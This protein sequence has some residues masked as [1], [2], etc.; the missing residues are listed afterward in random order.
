MSE[1]RR[2]SGT[3]DESPNGT[4]RDRVFI[5]DTT[6]RDGEQSPGISL[7]VQEKLEIAHQLA[8]LGVDVIEAG[9]PITSPGDMKAVSAI[10]KAVEGPIICGL[11]RTSAQD[12]DAAW[13]AV[14]YS[15]RPRIHTFIA[16]SDI[17][18]ERK[19]QTTREDVVGQARAAV[20][21]AKEFC[22][23]VE[24]SPEDGSRS[25]VEFMAEV[26]KVALEEGAT[27]IN[28]P[29][30]VGYT[31]P[32]EYGEMFQR[33][34]ELVPELADVVVSVH[35]HDDLGLAVANSFAGVLAGARQVECAVNGI[36]ERAGN[37]ALEEI[38]MLLRTRRSSIGLDTGIKTQEIARTSR[39]VSRL[40][41]YP[42]QP[43][44]AIVGRNAFAHEAGIHLDGVLKDRT[45]YEIMDATTIGLQ[46]NQLVLGKHSGRHALRNALEE[47]GV[48]VDGQALNTA[49][50]RFKEIAD[51]KKKVTA[52][53]LEAIV[54]DE[55]REQAEAYNLASFDIHDASGIPPSAKVDVTTPTGETVS[56]EG[57]GDGAVDAL[58]RAINAATGLAGVLKEYHVAAVTPDTDALG[59]VSLL[60]ELEGK[61]APGQG[62]STDTLEATG[63]AYLRALS[64]AMAGVTAADAPLNE[65]SE[66][67]GEPAGGP[68]AQEKSSTT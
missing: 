32:D 23:D 13:N 60:V 4:Q 20:A 27:T 9:F 3:K 15:E 24:F 53:D 66:G 42:V 35:C 33:L 57:T 12:I 50:K 21:H 61:L 25:D 29:D 31:M 10:A 7:N 28:I 44:K 8:R 38:V 34:Y 58:L 45:T 37:A 39:L 63:R 19:L 40:T 18:I 5:F 46:T 55:I 36:G 6:L 56:G 16:T 14:K 17:H 43:N 62:L 67:G 64:N 2:T 48:R 54:S 11:A 65:D 52:L 51:K 59:E 47:L 41:G 49:F 68:G 1:R 22:D 26:V 30:T